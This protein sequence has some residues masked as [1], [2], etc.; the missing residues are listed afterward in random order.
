M[1]YTLPKATTSTLGGVR[2]D[3]VTITIDEQGVISSASS[4]S[5]IS[6]TI[7]GVTTVQLLSEIITPIDGATG[8]VTHDFD[9]GSSIFYHTNVAA[10]FTANFT[11]VPTTN[12]RSYFMTLIIQQGGTPYIPHAIS[13]DNISQI[14]YW[15]DNT[16]PTGTANK[17]EYFTFNLLRRNDAWT[18]T[19]G[20]ATYG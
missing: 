4:G 17:F 19:A 2:V 8:T 7:T 3:G 20:V 1:S 14:I 11:N 18:I 13:V 16:Q 6:P 9:T 5:F 15:V 12:N 10:S